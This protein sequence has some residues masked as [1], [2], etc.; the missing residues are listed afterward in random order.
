[1]QRNDQNSLSQKRYKETIRNLYERINSGDETAWAEVNDKNNLDLV[2][3]AEIAKNH[4]L[5]KKLR[6]WW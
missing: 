5:I 3:L 1:M 6:S 2:L 4:D